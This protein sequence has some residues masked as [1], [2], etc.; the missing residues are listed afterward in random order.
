MENAG[1]ENAGSH[2]KRGYT[3]LLIKLSKGDIKK[4]FDKF[5]S[6]VRKNNKK[7]FAV[8]V[9]KEKRNILRTKHGYKD[10]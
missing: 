10:F 7:Q 9:A 8:I 2:G 6:S 1:M 5:R 4:Q 3:R